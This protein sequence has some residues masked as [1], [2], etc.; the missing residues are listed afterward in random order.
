MIIVW[1]G[2]NVIALEVSAIAFVMT[3]MR[4][5]A[6]ATASGAREEHLLQMVRVFMG[7]LARFAAG[8]GRGASDRGALRKFSECS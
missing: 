5:G 4:V 7:P 6:H 2:S 1:F 8:A 3:F